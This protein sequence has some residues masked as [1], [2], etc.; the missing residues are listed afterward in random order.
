MIRVFH[1]VALAVALLGCSCSSA[2]DFS[3]QE[4][5][6]RVLAKEDALSILEVQTGLNSSPKKTDGAVAALASV[7]RGARRFPPEQGFISLDLDEP[8]D[9]KWSELERADFLEFAANVKVEESGL[10]S[11]ELG[12]LCFVRRTRIDHLRRTLEIVNAY[13]NRMTLEQRDRQSANKEEFRPDFPFYDVATRDAVHAAAAS[14]HAWLSL[15]DGALVLDYPM[16][17]SGA[18]RCASELATGKL[19]K[20]NAMLIAQTSSIR[21]ADGRVLLRFGEP[22][23]PVLNFSMP[24]SKSPEEA[25]DPDLIHAAEK[26]GLPIGDAAALKRLRAA[27][28]PS[29]APA[30]VPK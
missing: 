8:E 10:F 24:K 9:E 29:S 16:S 15:R 26:H 18:A 4:L 20:D 30:A 21:S 17:E 25:F 1:A 2:Y 27:F 5:L 23:K 28:E 11:E 7:L 19:H 6:V 12:P 22:H 3:E 13:C 14:G